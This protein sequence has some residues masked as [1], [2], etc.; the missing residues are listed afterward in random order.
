MKACFAPGRLKNWK[1]APLAASAPT[2]FDTAA[3]GIMGSAA[4]L[5]TSTRPLNAGFSTGSGMAPWKL[6][7]T[8]RGAP[9]CAMSST[10][11]PPKQ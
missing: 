3:A 8:K 2:Y 11:R 4:P 10:M 5:K 7:A 1:S 9:R 6:P